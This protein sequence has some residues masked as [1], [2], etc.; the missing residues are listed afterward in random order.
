MPDKG[1]KQYERRIARDFGVERTP[2][3]GSAS[4]HTASDTLHAKLFIDVKVR[5][6]IRTLWRLFKAI[7][8]LAMRERKRPVLIVKV[9]RADDLDSIVAC[10]LRD[11]QMI[12]GE[13][14]KVGSHADG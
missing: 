1:F 12:A 8:G 14:A 6:E 7:E 13:L 2:L 10:R 11:V 4:R 9:P 5:R 3:S